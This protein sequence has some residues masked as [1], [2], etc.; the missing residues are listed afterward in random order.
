MEYHEVSNWVRLLELV[1]N[2]V[3]VINQMLGARL[4]GCVDNPCRITYRSG[5]YTCTICGEKFV[6]FTI[7]DIEETSDALSSLSVLNDGLWLLRRSGR[8]DFTECQP[9]AN[10]C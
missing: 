7:Y 6:T 9:T 5:R 1:R 4:D 2:R 10:A 3:S 8:Y